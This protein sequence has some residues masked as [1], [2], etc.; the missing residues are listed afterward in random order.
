MKSL[1]KYLPII[2]IATFVITF[3][4]MGWSQ[5]LTIA[6]FK[7]YQH[8]IQDFIKHNYL[9]SMLIFLLIDTAIVS[10]SI[11][12]I[13]LTIMAG[14]LY[15]PYI[16]TLLALI[17]A[18]IGS[19][20]L[21]LSTRSAVP[22]TQSKAFIE[23]LRKGFQENAFFYLLSLRLTPAIPFFVLTLVSAFL[24][25][26]FRTFA[27]ATFLGAIPGTF[28]FAFIGNA[29][30]ESFETLTINNDLIIGLAALG[31]LS[32]LPVVIQFIKKLIRKK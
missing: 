26:P 18:T 14:F 19:C 2:F 13:F 3:W 17:S 30:E 21:F 24:K 32:F 7:Q 11:P 10:I 16:A 27:V 23:K 25:I 6:T 4:T 15:G 5:Y 1:R 9:L 8:Q 29:L 12:T 22:D 31:V 28:V 20:I